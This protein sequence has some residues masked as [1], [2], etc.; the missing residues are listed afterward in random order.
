MGGETICLRRLFF[1]GTFV[2]M[3]REGLDRYRTVETRQ[4]ATAKKTDSFDWLPM[5]EGTCSSGELILLLLALED[6]ETKDV[7][8]MGV[9][10]HVCCVLFALSAPIVVFCISFTDI[11][12]TVPW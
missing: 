12:S 1:D 4:T 7:R 6:M 5:N 3:A 11:E 10:C 9:C 8:W 2:R